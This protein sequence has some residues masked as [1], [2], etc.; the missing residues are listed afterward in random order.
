MNEI[1][2]PTG[3][4]RRLTLDVI[5]AGKRLGLGRNASYEAAKRGDLPTIK[6][7]GRIL[8]PIVR[9]EKLLNGEA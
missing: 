8:V 7:G 2:A 4:V 6:I 5:E 3:P 9:L 1:E